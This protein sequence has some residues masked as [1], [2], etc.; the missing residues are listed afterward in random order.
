MMDC[1]MENMTKLFA[2]PLLAPFA[3]LCPHLW[4][5]WIPQTA[6]TG[7]GEYARPTTVQKPKWINLLP[8]LLGQTLSKLPPQARGTANC[9]EAL[10]QVVLQLH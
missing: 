8:G 5:N 10:R 6:P 7:V 1:A 9:K 4:S 3:E 2:L